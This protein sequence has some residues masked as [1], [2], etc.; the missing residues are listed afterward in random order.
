MIRKSSTNDFKSIYDVINEAA[1]SYKGV[2]PDE[3]WKE[4]YMSKDELKNEIEEGVEFWVYE[5]KG[6]IYGVMGI[7]RKYDI[8][9]IRHAYVCPAKQNRGIGGKLLKHLQDLTTRPILIATW[10]GATHAIRFYKK[11][12]FKIVSREEGVRLQR[13]FW[14]TPELKINSSVVF[15][16]KRWLKLKSIESTNSINSFS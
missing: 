12:G 11:Y 6:K 16:D 4:P 9:L 7:Q 2:I 5:D 14:S 13:K 15:A 10:S 3:Y 1:Q 8:T